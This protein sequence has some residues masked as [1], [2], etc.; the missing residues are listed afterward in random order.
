[1]QL[2]QGV[3]HFYR[4]PLGLLLAV[5]SISATLFG[6]FL[7]LSPV[8]SQ[9]VEDSWPV[10]ESKSFSKL[11]RQNPSQ[12]KLAFSCSAFGT[13]SE[14]AFQA[15]GWNLALSGN[16]LIF[17]TPADSNV[18][19]TL[20]KDYPP[21]IVEV[22]ID[23]ST[24]TA[25]VI[26]STL[27]GQLISKHEEFLDDQL[28]LRYFWFTG[29]FLD[30][31][32]ELKT[33]SDSFYVGQTSERTYLLWLTVGAWLVFTMLTVFTTSQSSVVDVRQ[34]LRGPVK[35]IQKFFALEKTGLGINLMVLAGLLVAAFAMPTR[36]DDGW[37]FFRAQ[38]SNG[39]GSNPE[40]FW[41]GS[42]LLFQGILAEGLVARLAESGLGFYSIRALIVLP[43]FLTWLV[44]HGLLRR[45]WP[46]Y[47]SGPIGVGGAFFVTGFAGHLVSLRPEYLI[48]LVSALLLALLFDYVK[49]PSLVVFHLATALTFFAVATHQSA[50]LLFGPVLIFAVYFVRHALD[51]KVIVRSYTLSL[52]ANVGLFFVFV[53]SQL[54][55]QTLLREVNIWLRR[56][57]YTGQN[58]LDRWFS[59]FSEPVWR[60]WPF[61][62]FGVVLL[63]L[64]AVA[65]SLSQSEKFVTL[66]ALSSFAGVFLT[67]SKWTW[68]LGVLLPSMTLTTVVAF[69]L[70]ETKWRRS[71]S[72]WIGAPYLAAAFA[73]AYFMNLGTDSW[74]PALTPVWYRNGPF[75]GIISLE[76]Q[77]LIVLLAVLSLGV[78]SAVIVR[79]GNV[80]SLNLVAFLLVIG[81]ITWPIARLSTS[82]TL[83]AVVVKTWTPLKQQ[84]SLFGSKY[85]CGL[86]T[87]F[88][89]VD[90]SN[91]PV[92]EPK[93]TLF[94]SAEA[95]G[96]ILATEARLFGDFSEG[97][98]F[99]VRADR[100]SEFGQ[101]FEWKALA[102]VGF[103]LGSIVD[104][105]TVPLPEVEVFGDRWSM[106]RI[107]QVAG[108][109]EV[110]VSSLNGPVPELF[111][112]APVAVDRVELREVASSALVSPALIPYFPCLSLA[113]ISGSR[114]EQPSL[115]IDLRADLP[116]RAEDISFQPVEIG[117]IAVSGT[118]VRAYHPQARE[119]QT[120]PN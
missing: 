2:R 32:T 5:S 70:L 25:E 85:K 117:S 61:L 39:L 115:L 51:G 41:G 28:S 12:I 53:F 44:I 50:A 35:N 13:P 99:W 92:L 20:Q 47:R 120:F 49:S 89:V 75:R 90:F 119:L 8:N 86:E 40:F 23:N 109:S 79:F 31:E 37:V 84:L 105:R 38:E 114:I 93:G 34:T 27:N 3:R 63:T 80:A 94:E 116:A 95:D 26:L 83:D 24:N 65:N 67:G 45:L 73:G 57:G 1:M 56:S 111:I 118:T 10:A 4:R 103:S 33:V 68:H 48:A 100:D 16:E 82:V 78:L 54:D 98:V 91:M 64:I 107:P 97:A 52:L 42:A 112:T 17:E 58:E 43:A 77:I 101:A 62:I 11:V 87:D 7:A 15:S 46:T 22:D 21:C 6:L 113:G 9:P 14:T 36:Y 81:I 19:F 88:R 60:F 18:W 74:G 108:V 30:S 106:V 72:A 102:E 59:L 104:N 76:E 69:H 71:S 66:V 96:S 110:Q 55:V 29:A